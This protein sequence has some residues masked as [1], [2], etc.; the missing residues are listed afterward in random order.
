MTWEEPS[1]V[2]LWLKNIRTIDKVQITDPSKYFSFAVITDVLT[3][4]SAL[5]AKHHAMKT[6]TGNG[7]TAIRFI[8][9]CGRWK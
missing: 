1:L 2:T 6:C 3:N 8:N 4:E 5:C 7:V 9:F